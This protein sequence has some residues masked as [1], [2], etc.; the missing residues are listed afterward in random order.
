MLGQLE[1]AIPVEITVYVPGCWKDLVDVYFDERELPGDTISYE[2]KPVL[3]A[4]SCRTL[5]ND[6]ALYYDDHRTRQG[7]NIEGWLAEVHLC[8]GQ[9]HYWGEIHIYAPD[10]ELV[11]E[12]AWEAFA[13]TNE[14]E[15]DGTVRKF[16]VKIVWE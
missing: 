8:S 5:D 14:L 13:D 9:S 3:D 12:S 6:S 4:E 2:F 16:V 1:L 7:K 10:G 15:Q 11:I